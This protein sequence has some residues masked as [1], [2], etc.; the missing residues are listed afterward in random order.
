[1]TG[2]ALSPFRLSP[3]RVGQL[4]RPRTYTSNF[5]M[6]VIMWPHAHAFSKRAFGRSNPVGKMLRSEFAIILEEAIDS[7]KVVTS[8]GVVGW[9]DSWDIALF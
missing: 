1:M 7:V 6:E 2:I 3:F 4:V 9:V 8:G 5:D